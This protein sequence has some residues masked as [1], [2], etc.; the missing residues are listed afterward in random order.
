[1]YAVISNISKTVHHLLKLRASNIAIKQML[2]LL[3]L[4]FLSEI[5]PETET[6]SS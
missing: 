6:L 3:F 1:M 2:F 4:N 5:K